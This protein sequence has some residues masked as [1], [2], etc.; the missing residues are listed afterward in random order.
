MLIYSFLIIILDPLSAYYLLPNVKIDITS[1]F[2]PIMKSVLY[3]VI[4]IPYML[5]SERVKATFVNSGITIK[6]SRSEKSFHK[7]EGIRQAILALWITMGISLLTV[8][9]DVLLGDI[10]TSTFILQLIVGAIFCLFPYKINNGSNLTRYIYAA[11]TIL[12]YVF[13][14]FATRDLSTVCSGQVKLATFLYSSQNCF[15]A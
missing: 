14:S 3:M 10:S 15:S 4:L 13:V 11:I 12:S 6:L 2:K 8:V 5:R 9:L 7:P 1:S